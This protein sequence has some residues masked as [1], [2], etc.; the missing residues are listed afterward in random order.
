[1]RFVSG[2]SFAR[3]LYLRGYLEG[4]ADG[5]LAMEQLATFVSKDNPPNP[6]AAPM[7][8]ATP[9]AQRI[10][11]MSGFEKN[12]DLTLGQ[13]ID[14]TTAF[15]NDYRNAPVCWKDALQ[16]SVRAL[17]GDPATETDLASA[18]KRGAESG[19]K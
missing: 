13:V 18:R 3:L 19:C 4:Y 1:L 6:S 5:E 8:A 7:Q 16:F 14:A 2:Y 11:R 10:A 9:M 15:Y 12:A 17:N